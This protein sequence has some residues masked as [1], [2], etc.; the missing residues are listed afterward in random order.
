MSVSAEE[1]GEGGSRGVVEWL[2][3]ATGILALNSLPKEC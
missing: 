2:Y 3:H 1:L